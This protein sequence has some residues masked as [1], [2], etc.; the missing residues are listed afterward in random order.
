M[1]EVKKEKLNSVFGVRPWS[2]NVSHSPKTMAID[3][4]AV[5]ISE[6]FVT[7]GNILWVILFGW[8]LAIPF[9]A[10]GILLVLTFISRKYGFVCFSFAKYLFWPFGRYIVAKISDDEVPMGEGAHLVYGEQTEAGGPAYYIFLFFSAFTIF[11]T[12]ILGTILNWFFVVPIPMAKVLYNLLKLLLRR[13]TSISV[14]SEYTRAQSFSV[15]LCTYRAFNVLYFEYEVKGVNIVFLNLI[16][17]VLSRVMIILYEIISEHHGTFPTLVSFFVNILCSV[18]ITF[19]IGTSIASI[20]CQTNYTIGAILN[21]TFGS[22]TE[23][24]LFTMALRDGNLNELI[25]FSLTGSLLCDMLLLPGLSMI[26]GGFK[27]KE[28]KF[29]PTAAAVSSL[30]LFVAVIGAFTPTV[31]YHLFGF[32]NQSCKVCTNEI[33]DNVTMFVCTDCAFTQDIAHDP[34]YTQSVK[35]LLY[36]ACGL[37]PTAYLIG[38]IFTFK[39][40]KHIFDEEE[41]EEGNAEWSILFSVFVMLVSVACFG[42]LAEDLVSLLQFVL[43]EL[44][45]TQAFMG[46]TVIALTPAATEIANAI[47]FALTNQISLSVSIGSASSIQVALIQMPSLVLLSSIISNDS[48]NFHLVFPLMSVFAVLLAVLT[49]NYISAEGNTNYFVGSVLVVMYILLIASFYF[50]PNSTIAIPTNSSNEH[51]F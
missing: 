31:F 19:Y 17:V 24:L 26:V 51:H 10:V 30:L 22:V 45:L 21:A 15:L 5:E 7:F 18:P 36:I 39:T 6:S 33:K 29:N 25:L 20:A 42:I 3:E 46:V 1:L 12:L 27:Y 48:S 41:G 4:D 38:L 28:Q 32:F 35:K 34:L 37:L 43:E 14:I 11:P 13:P 16:P 50:I 23:L 40:H 49:F 9:V 2:H 8:W 47:K 44:N